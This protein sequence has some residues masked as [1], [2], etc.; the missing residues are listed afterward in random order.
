MLTKNNIF[1][2]FFS[3]LF[4]VYDLFL[5]SPFSLLS[6][7]LAP[8]TLCIPKILLSLITFFLF[9]FSL[10]NYSLLTIIEIDSCGCRLVGLGRSLVGVLVEFGWCLGQHLGWQLGGV[11]IGIQGGNWVVFGLAFGWRL[12]RSLGWRLG[13]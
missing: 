9:S 11:W 8:L 1:Y 7:P 3:S 13:W 10:V 6:S 2:S 12:G 4:S 5:P